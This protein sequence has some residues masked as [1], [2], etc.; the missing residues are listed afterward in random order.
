MDNF[1]MSA[2]ICT[3]FGLCF[4]QWI[5]RQQQQSLT[6]GDFETL[7]NDELPGLSV[8]IAAKDE[9]K[10]IGAALDSLLELDYPDLEIILIEDRSQDRTLEIAQSK[11]TDH[12]RGQRLKVI[13]CRELPEGWLGKVHALHLGVKN[14]KKA[15]V[16]LTDADV[17]FEKG[18]LRR[19]VSAQQVLH[20][21][22]LVAAPAVRTKGFWEPV[23][24]AFFLLMF[25]I[26]FRPHRVHLEKKNYVGIGAFNLLTRE[27]L[28]SC[29]YLEPLKLQIIEDV[30]LGRLVKS[31]GLSQHC[32][33]AENWINVRW[34]EGL[35]G[36]IKGLE[37]NAYAG[38][39]YSIGLALV[40][41]PAI[42]SPAL[43]PLWLVASG[44]FFWVS[45][46]L[47]FLTLLGLVAVRSCP[48]PKW[49]GLFF[50]LASVILTYTFIR[51]IV[52]AEFRQGIE[53]RDTHYPLE[54]LRKEH[55]RFLREEAPM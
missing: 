17:V 31:R 14:A 44:K 30:H 49:V 54:N 7:V 18:A 48:L 10:T 50:P 26:R 1:D 19:A 11:I 51:S 43:I 22:H 46:Y 16:L 37:K 8:V 32:L 4:L 12:A 42:L 3:I 33:V 28:E 53:W 24:V 29:Q 5:F 47:T 23:L 21:D 6:L 2:M 9:E 41:L 35:S 39:Y 20:C 55:W 45:V 40:S 34:F 15:L 36:C 25:S 38:L 13:P 52:L 27:A